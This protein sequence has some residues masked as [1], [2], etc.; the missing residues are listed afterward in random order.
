MMKALPGTSSHA[1]EYRNSGEFGVCEL[2]E[3]LPLLREQP[4][5]RDAVNTCVLVHAVLQRPSH[6][7]R[8]FINHSISLNEQGRAP[9]Y[10]ADDEWL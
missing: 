1:L 2:S 7:S 5:L 4:R 8:Q 10:R 9:C 3:A 6:G